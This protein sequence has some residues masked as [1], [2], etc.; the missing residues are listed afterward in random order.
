M[1]AKIDAGERPRTGRPPTKVGRVRYKR[2][3]DQLKEHLGDWQHAG[4]LSKR[5]DIPHGLVAA[6]LRRAAEKGEVHTV[7]TNP[8]AY[9]LAGVASAI[10]NLDPETII[11]EMS[12]SEESDAVPIE[13]LRWLSVHL[14][15]PMTLDE[16][17][18]GTRARMDQV[19]E[20]VKA[21]IVAD[22]IA[23][24]GEE[25]KIYSLTGIP[26]EWLSGGVGQV[27]GLRRRLE[28]HIKGS[29]TSSQIVASMG[30]TRERV[31][32]ILER[33]EQRGIVERIEDRPLRFRIRPEGKAVGV[34]RV[35]SPFPPVFDQA[36][37]HLAITT[38]AINVLTQAGIRTVGHLVRLRRDEIASLPGM[39]RKSVDDIV[40]G[41]AEMGLM[42]GMEEAESYPAP[43]PM[44]EPPD[45]AQAA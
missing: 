2:I 38:R 26:D 18:N 43:E 41:L 17:C 39:G 11:A 24:T 9:R 20:H 19:V 13:S 29:M 31:R 22:C 4:A 3:F 35:E 23:V 37:H 10:P 14:T 30:L 36:V 44:P 32:Q 28:R 1:L 21:G 33:A 40:L 8:T 45:E 27:S 7:R 25:P 6:V 42:P 34:P 5:L 15:A 16:L 12:A